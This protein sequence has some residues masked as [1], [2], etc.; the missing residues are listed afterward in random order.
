MGVDLIEKPEC[1]RFQRLRQG[2]VDGLVRTRG[3]GLKILQVHLERRKRDL[4]SLQIIGCFNLADTSLL[5]RP[6]R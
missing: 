2:G 6:R 5:D 1:D 3:R 4:R